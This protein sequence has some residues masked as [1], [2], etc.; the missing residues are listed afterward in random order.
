MPFR[1]LR[2]LKCSHPSPNDNIDGPFN[3]VTRRYSMIA[4]KKHPI[5]ITPGAKPAVRYIPDLWRAD[6]SEGANFGYSMAET[7]TTS[8]KRR[9]TVRRGQRWDRYW[10]ARMA[11]DDRG[12]DVVGGCH[13]GPPVK[14]EKGGVRESC[15]RINRHDLLN[16]DGPFPISGIAFEGN[17]LFMARA[18]LLSRPLG[19][20][21]LP[22]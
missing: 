12:S 15:G 8:A 3:F 17:H 1:P 2:A 10:R 7:R 20:P 14:R 18:F 16:D 5:I 13:T 21:F 11:R 9:D 22:R 19:S 6:P 4:Q